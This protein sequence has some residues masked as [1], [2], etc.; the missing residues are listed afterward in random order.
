V[1]TDLWH[2]FDL[3]VCRW[4]IDEA[5]IETLPEAAVD[6]LVAGCDTRSLALLAGMDH[7]SWSEIGPVLEQVLIEREVKPPT[8]SEATTA[9][10]NDL[11]RQ[12]VDG[13]LG[14]RA[15]TYDL[16]RLSVAPGAVGSD[17]LGAFAGF[18][19]AFEMAQSGVWGSW[20]DVAT[21]ALTYAKELIAEGGLPKTR[22]E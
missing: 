8:R 20:E 3:A 13:E 16:Y 17:G 6:A 18:D 7:R 5:P 15:A 4:T 11:L 1:V 10:G 9:I 22:S 19:D 2:Q 14:V 12:M 21:A